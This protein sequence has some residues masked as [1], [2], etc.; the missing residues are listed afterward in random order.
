[1]G[2]DHA[3]LF[4]TNK[5]NEPEIGSLYGYFPPCKA[6]FKKYGMDGNL[7]KPHK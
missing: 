4:K 2:S 7:N 3:K 1:M 6:W 5:L